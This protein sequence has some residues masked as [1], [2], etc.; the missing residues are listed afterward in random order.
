MYFRLK[1]NRARKQNNSKHIFLILWLTAVAGFATFSSVPALAGVT[2]IA[3]IHPT[4]SI[5]LLASLL[6]LSSLF[7]LVLLLTSL[8]CCLHPCFCWHLFCSLHPLCFLTLLL[9]VFL[10]CCCVCMKFL[11]L[12]VYLMLL[13][14]LCCWPSSVSDV[15]SA[16]CVLDVLDVHYTAVAPAVISVY[17]VVGLSA[18]CCWLPY[19]CKNMYM[20]L[21][22]AL[23]LETS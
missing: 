14:S 22:A 15:P 19:L 17:A 4:S 18:C 23:I 16:L 2:P 9:S 1:L 7:R 12:L 5:P 8:Y 21:L 10:L 3:S 6:L 13:A 20:L 11:L